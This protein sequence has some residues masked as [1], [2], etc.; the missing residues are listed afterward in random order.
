MLFVKRERG[1]CSRHPPSGIRGEREKNDEDYRSSSF[2][3][4]LAHQSVSNFWVHNYIPTYI[5]VDKYFLVERIRI[6]ELLKKFPIKLRNST[7]TRRFKKLF[8][9]ESTWKIPE[10]RIGGF[11][12]L[13]P[14]GWIPKNSKKMLTSSLKLTLKI[15]EFR[16]SDWWIFMSTSGWMNPKK[17]YKKEEI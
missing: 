16:N 11:L 8:E 7:L 13:L 6:P 15:P 17:L 2:I 5:I 9:S 14:D 10:F 4:N 12:C 1:W 3:H